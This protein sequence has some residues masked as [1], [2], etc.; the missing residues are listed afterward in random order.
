VYRFEV[1]AD[2]GVRLTVAGLRAIDHW[3][4]SDGS[5]T[6]V[7]NV[8]VNGPSSLTLEYYEATGGAFLFYNAVRVPDGTP[9]SVSLAI[10]N[11]FPPPVDN[12]VVQVSAIGQVTAGTL[13]VR[14]QPGTGGQVLTKINFGQFYP[15][16]ASN[17]DRS[18]YLIRVGIIEGWVSARFLR[19]SNETASPVIPPVN[20]PAPIAPPVIVPTAVPPVV[21]PGSTGLFLTVTENLII[22]SQPN[23]QS[24]QRGLIAAGQSAE[25]LGRNSSG[26]WWYV[27][28][29]LQIGWISGRYVV[30]PAGLDVNRVPVTAR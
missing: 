25:I 13:N 12:T 1:R 20:L 3:Y 4:P 2:D 16:I 29:N 27:T 26:T 22:R 10:A 24:T 7:A 21:A 18:W 9:T 28:Q 17:S 5:A 14:N 8:Y 19:I 23:T 6:H 15:V 11:P 30:L